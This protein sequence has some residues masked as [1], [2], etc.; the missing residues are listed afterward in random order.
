[1]LDLLVE[2]YISRR[3]LQDKIDKI[4]TLDNNTIILTLID[5]TFFRERN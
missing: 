5:N 1:M 3:T 4:V 2:V